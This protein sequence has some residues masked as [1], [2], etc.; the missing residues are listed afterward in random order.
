VKDAEEVKLID[1]LYDLSET[2]RSFVDF[3][4]LFANK[5]RYPVNNLRNLALVNAPT[6]LVMILD[7]DFV[8]SED[9]HGFLSMAGK[10]LMRN[11]KRNQ[12]FVVPAFSSNL[13]PHALPKF[14]PALLASLRSKTVSQVNELPCP[15]CHGPTNYKKWEKTSEL[16]ETEY[17]WIYEPYLMLN[18]DHLT[19][20][21]DERLKGYGFDKNTHVFALAAAGYQFFVL[22]DP[23]IIHVNHEVVQWDGPSIQ[24][25]LWDALQIVCRML[26]AIRQ[27]NGYDPEKQLFDEPVGNDCFSRSHW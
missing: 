24:D 2:V 5:T 14:K 11:T 20:L 25:Q 17:K 8:T 7:A 27:K 6:S 15:K 19:E 21:F 3:H 13:A 1:Q 23:F 12:A 10:N 4:I 18:K 26:P 22:P 9:M 16:Y